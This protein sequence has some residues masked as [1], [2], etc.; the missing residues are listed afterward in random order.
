MSGIGKD[1]VHCLSAFQERGAE[2]GAVK[3]DGRLLGVD[4]AALRARLLESRDRIAATAGIASDGSWT[5][6]PR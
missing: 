5:P 1:P 4:L 2:A 6:P 3:R